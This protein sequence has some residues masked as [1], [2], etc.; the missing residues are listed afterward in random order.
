MAP[1]F[2]A[3]KP[4]ASLLI[5]VLTGP[6]PSMPQKQPPLSADR[7]QVLR[8]WILAGARDDSPAGASTV[9]VR[10]PATYQTAPAVTSVALSA[11]GK[12]L[13]AACRSEVVLVDVEGKAAPRRLATTSDLVT[14]VAFSPDGKVLAAAGGSP[15]RFGEVAFYNPAT[16]QL[17]SRRRVG[18]DTLF[19]G[20]FS[21][22]G[23]GLALGGPDGSIHIVP[24]KAKEQVSHFELH[25]DWV[26]DVAYTPDGKYLITAGRD[27]TT[28]IASA[29]TG[30]LLRT[31]DTSSD[32][33]GAASCRWP[34]RHRGGAGRHAHRL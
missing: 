18:K 9:E 7:V 12:L 16:G 27:K 25:S 8:L 28:K 11:D 21:P 13:A 19:R 23:K 34:V 30:A 26:L 6:E 5:E 10:A 15:G 2:K 24:V 3:G 14:H 31:L 29:K 20:S 32:R 17:L 33:L 4:D 22:D 1:I